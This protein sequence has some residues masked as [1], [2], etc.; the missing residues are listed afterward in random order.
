MLVC[1]DAT[2]LCGALRRPTGPNFR[3]LELAAEGVVVEGFTTEVVGMEFVRNALEGLGGVQY[4]I[5][6]VEEFLDAFGALFDPDRVATSPVGRSLTNQTW[7]HNRP[8][9]E[10][11]YHLTGNRRGRVPP[12]REDP[13]GPS[14]GPA[15]HNCASS[16]ETSTPTTCILSLPLS[17]EAPM[18]SAALTAAAYLRVGLPATFMSSDRAGARSTS[19][20]HRAPTMRGNER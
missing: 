20:S 7:L 13:R 15:Y 5:A 19:A 2:V 10:V 9:G 16:A 6:V 11:V 14:G 18:S 17:R 3:L 8:I 4:E 1:F 12:D